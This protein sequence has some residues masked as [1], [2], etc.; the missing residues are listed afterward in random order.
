MATAP[1]AQGVPRRRRARGQR[2]A[3]APARVTIVSSLAGT[4]ACAAEAPV[5]LTTIARVTRAGYPGG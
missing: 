1:A 5:P 4:M 3:A 2:S